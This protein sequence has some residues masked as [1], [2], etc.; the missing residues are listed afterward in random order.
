MNRNLTL[1]WII[2]LVLLLWQAWGAYDQ[3]PPQVPSHFDF[4]DQPNGYSDKGSFF[5]TWLLAILVLNAL[6][7]GVR[8]LLSKVPASTINVPHREYW[9]ATPERRA[10]LVGKMSNLMAFSIT[11]VNIMLFLIFRSIVSYTLTRH[12]G[13]RLWYP[14]LIVP[15]IVV[16]PIIYILRTFRIPDSTSHSQV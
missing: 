10:V 8:L 16:G 1:I 5:R 14:M 3:L 7:P 2:T 15:V 4:H 11:G 9:L 12:T 13:M 6:V